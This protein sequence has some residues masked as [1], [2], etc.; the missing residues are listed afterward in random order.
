MVLISGRITYGEHLSSIIE[1][2]EDNSYDILVTSET[3]KQNERPHIHFLC[4]FDKTLS[5]F[6]QRL[7]KRFE[8]LKGNAEYSLKEIPSQEKDSAVRY[9]CKGTR[10][11]PPNILINQLDIDTED[12]HKRY[13]EVNEKV[14]TTKGK[15]V[16]EFV[17]SESLGVFKPKSKPV[18]WMV[19]V[20]DELLQ[21]AEF[22]KL[23]SVKEVVVYVYDHVLK[24]LGDDVKQADGSIARKNT[25]GLVNS[26]RPLLLREYIWEESG[27][28]K[29]FG[30]I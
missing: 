1:Y 10:T 22:E 18:P 17:T 5:T 15:T 14:K 29:L 2:F 4:Q 20:K 27:F 3:G 7:V 24:R 23:T 8:F 30:S 6:R 21:D 26:L 25:I 28:G 19:K 11:E 9:L 12:A 16:I 13:W